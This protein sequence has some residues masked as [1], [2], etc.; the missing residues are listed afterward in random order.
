MWSSADEFSGSSSS[1]GWRGQIT[2]GLGHLPGRKRAGVVGARNQAGSLVLPLG[3]G[4]KEKHDKIPKICGLYLFP[5]F[6]F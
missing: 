2:W 1:V 6:F 3:M 4:C 5:L